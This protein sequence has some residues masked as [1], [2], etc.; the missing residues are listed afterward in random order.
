MRV[1]QKVLSEET[2]GPQKAS[3]AKET[4]FRYALSRKALGISI[5]AVSTMYNACRLD[6]GRFSASAETPGAGFPIPSRGIK[7]LT[8]REM[9]LGS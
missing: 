1:G 8:E 4:S 7:G 3:V 6:H 2:S 5:L 9:I